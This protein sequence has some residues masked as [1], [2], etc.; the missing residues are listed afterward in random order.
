MSPGEANARY[1]LNQFDSDSIVNFANALLEEGVYLDSLGELCTM[2]KPIM[3]EAGP[4]FVA[5]L[6]ELGAWNT[7][8]QEAA[9]VLLESGLSRISK[10]CENL[11]EE[12]EFL[13]LNVHHEISDELPDKKYVGDSLGLER[14]FCWLREIWDCRDG[15]ML[16]YYTDIPRNEAEQKFLE[17]LREAAVEW[18][19]QNTQQAVPPK[20]DRAGG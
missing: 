2:K 19:N 12:A 6:K 16:A 20:S 3:S 17:H 10:G 15:S 4:L 14:V 13:Y 1:H 9:K 7:D 8:R 11:V 18:L 5:A